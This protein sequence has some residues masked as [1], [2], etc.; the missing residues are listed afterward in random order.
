MALVSAI[1][2][3]ASLF[4][5]LQNSGIEATLMTE[6]VNEVYR[7]AQEASECY[8]PVATAAFT[9]NTATASITHTTIVRGLEAYSTDITGYARLSFIP[10]SVRK[11]AELRE[12]ST[13]SGIPRYY[14]ITPNTAT[15][16]SE[17]TVYP[18]PSA[19][20][21]FSL[22][23]VAVT[24]TDLTAS[25]TPAALPTRYHHKVISNGVI[26]MCFDRE[27]KHD[28]ADVYWARQAK[29]LN[30]LTDWVNEL[31]GERVESHFLDVES[32]GDTDQSRDI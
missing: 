26:A 5:G 16:A 11:M 18:T 29:A 1:L 20:F 10:V 15:G 30:E 31:Q 6:F 22:K 24:S 23:H 12:G 27:G 19:A 14:T 7:D 4:T 28:R 17:I 21:T 2:S 32:I 13:S 25:D 3:R 9:A 8:Q